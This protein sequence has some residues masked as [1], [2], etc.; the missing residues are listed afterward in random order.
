MNWQ[1]NWEPVVI[2]EAGLLDA[3]ADCRMTIATIEEGRAS[4]HPYVERARQDWEGPARVDFDDDLVSFDRQIASTI[5]QL[6]QTVL[7]CQREIAEAHEEQAR[8]HAQQDQWKAERAAELAAEAAA[9]EARRA[10]A[11]LAEKAVA[12]TTA[13]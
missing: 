10:A 7:G 2:D 13:R 9:E 5:A 11:L 4:L 6:Q 1:P 12:A 8:R 3:I